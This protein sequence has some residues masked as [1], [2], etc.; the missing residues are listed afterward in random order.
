MFIYSDNQ[1]YE[2]EV[3]AGSDWSKRIFKEVS[4]ISSLS[5]CLSACEV[6]KDLCH[7]AFYDGINKICYIGSWNV[8]TDYIISSTETKDVFVKKCK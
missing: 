6:D 7:L 5:F 2:M 3:M 4:G 1:T 8:N